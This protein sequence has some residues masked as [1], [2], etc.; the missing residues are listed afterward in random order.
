MKPHSDPLSFCAKNKEKYR[1]H[2]E[3]AHLAYLKASMELVIV[4]H[5]RLAGKRSGTVKANKINMKKCQKHC[6]T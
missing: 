3:E 4:E 2:R 1:N 5:R 6:E